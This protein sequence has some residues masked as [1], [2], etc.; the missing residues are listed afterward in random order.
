MT[1]CKIMLLKSCSQTTTTVPIKSAVNCN[2]R[3]RIHVK[4]KH[5]HDWRPSVDTCPIDCL[6]LE[7]VEE[8]GVSWRCFTQIRSPPPPLMRGFRVLNSRVPALMC[9]NPKTGSYKI[10][11][12]R[13]T[14]CK[15]LS[16]G[17]QALFVSKEGRRDQPLM[18]SE[19]WPAATAMSAYSICTNFPVGL[20][21]R[22][23]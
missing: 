15:N 5:A 6:P 22:L 9:P 16:F 1:K 14:S 23:H 21:N 11:N 20:Q 12:K 2:V 17:C 13:L 8:D 10:A 18:P 7:E 4:Y 19:V 3:C